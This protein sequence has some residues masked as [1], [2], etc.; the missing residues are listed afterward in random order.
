[1]ILGFRVQGS[2]LGGFGV[3]RFGF[4]ISFSEF[5]IWGLRPWRSKFG[6]WGLGLRVQ[7]L[8]HRLSEHETC[9]SFINLLKDA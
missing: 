9:H 5:K 1:M 7:D 3:Q 2:G 4:Q 8:G 6:A